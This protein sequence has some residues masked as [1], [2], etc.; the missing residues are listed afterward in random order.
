MQT[1]FIRRPLRS[2]L[3]A[4]AGIVR[5]LVTSVHN[6]RRKAVVIG[7]S[8]FVGENVGFHV[9]Q[10]QKFSNIWTILT[11]GYFVFLSMKSG[12]YVAKTFVNDSDTD[13]Q[14]CARHSNIDYL[15][16]L[17]DGIMFSSFTNYFQ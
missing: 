1:L 13:V 3:Q 10:L 2:S 15:N 6:N 17:G 5:Q 4:T 11:L 8:G 7:G 16:T 14:I 12:K 9:Q